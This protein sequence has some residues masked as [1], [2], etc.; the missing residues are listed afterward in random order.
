MADHAQ[1]F[2]AVKQCLSL[3]GDVWPV[4]RLVARHPQDKKRARIIGIN[5]GLLIGELARIIANGCPAERGAPARCFKL[6]DLGEHVHGER[7]GRIR[8]V[9]R[10]RD[11]VFIN[12]K[13]NELRGGVEP[14]EAVDHLHDLVEKRPQCLRRI[15]Q[16]AGIVIGCIRIQIIGHGLKARRVDHRRGQSQQIGIREHLAQHGREIGLAIRDQGRV[17]SDQGLIRGPA[18]NDF[19]I[20]PALNLLP[21]QEINQHAIAHALVIRMLVAGAHVALDAAVVV[22]GLQ[23]KIHRLRGRAPIQAQRALECAVAGAQGKIILRRA[24]ILEGVFSPPFQ[25]GA[26]RVG[27]GRHMRRGAGPRLRIKDVHDARQ[28]RR[29]QNP[30]RA[31]RPGFLA[32]QDDGHHFADRAH[33][34]AAGERAVVVVCLAGGAA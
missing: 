3:A 25:P 18:Q 27:Q 29:G 19:H 24:V 17:A 13:L 11:A 16:H 15:N 9:G 12:A 28:D 5:A 2:A 6:R 4:H 30:R 21:Q 1:R 34:Q 33:A 22:G 31:P 10:R 26:R 8:H 32:I 23:I 20:R 7:G 14:D